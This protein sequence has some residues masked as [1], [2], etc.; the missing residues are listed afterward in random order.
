VLDAASQNVDVG[1]QS[2]NNVN[3][4]A[5]GTA[6]LTN[7][8]VIAGNFNNQGSVFNAVSRTMTVG[9]NWTND[10]TFTCLTC[11]VEFNG[12]STQT[13]DANGSSGIGTS[14]DNADFN[15]ITVSGSTL[16]LINTEL[17][18]DGTL[19]I[20]A[21]K[22]VDLNGQTLD[23]NGTLVN[24]GTLQLQGDETVTDLT[25]DT[26]SGTTTYDG[27]GSYASLLLGDVY[28]NISFNGTGDWTLDD[29]LDIDGNL[30]QDA[31]ELLTAVDASTTIA[32]DGNWIINANATTTIQR[33]ST[34]G[35]GLGQTITA[36]NLTILAGGAMEADV[37][38]IRCY[39]LME[40]IS[41]CGICDAEGD[42]I[43]S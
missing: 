24:N 18:I 27:T 40:W 1:T 21:S 41:A 3:H 9:G 42:F 33:Q 15:N 14:D 30:T 23:L 35:N 32:V 4:T 34:S 8:I 25:M 11:T 43:C 28:N 12:G 2:L 38:K 7:D 26:D 19:Q 6:T 29:F 31:G 5:S 13:I 36:G 20:D 10:A 39:D 16:Q 17:E 37:D 22:F